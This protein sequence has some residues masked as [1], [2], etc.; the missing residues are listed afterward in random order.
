MCIVRN[1]G[2]A[3]PALLPGPQATPEGYYRYLPDGK[4][5]APE[6]I[7]Y[8]LMPNAALERA[9][10]LEDWLPEFKTNWGIMED[11]VFTEAEQDFARHFADR[12]GRFV[13]FFMA[14]KSGSSTD[15]AGHNRNALWKPEEWVELGDKLPRASWCE[16]RCRW[17]YL[18]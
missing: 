5:W 12:I 3:G 8:V 13:T 16:Y 18:G 9:I 14:G 10:R 2:A 7:D 1:Q 6:G 11:F 17:H 4:E 15:S